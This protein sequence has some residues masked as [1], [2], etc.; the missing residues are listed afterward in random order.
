MGQ[1]HAEAGTLESGRRGRAGGNR[2]LTALLALTGALVVLVFAGAYLLGVMSNALFFLLMAMAPLTLLSRTWG[3]FRGRLEYGLVR[4]P[5]NRDLRLH[6]LQCVNRSVF[7]GIAGLTIALCMVPIQIEPDTYFDLR[8]FLLVSTVVMIALQLVPP[9]RVRISTNISYALGWIFLAVEWLRVFL[10][11]AAPEGVVLSAP[12]RG[13]WYV[14]QGG[15]SALLNHHFVLR[16]QR[17]AL[18]LMKL[19]DGR[20]A[21]GDPNQLESYAA[22]GQPLFAP[23]AGRVVKAVNDRPD[24]AIGKSDEQ[25]IVGNHLIIEVRPDRYVLMAHL[26]KGSVSVA[27]GERVH[28]G[29]LIA[30]C[31]NS[32]NTSEPHLHLQVQNR[33]SF[34]SSD[35][36]TFPI[37]FRDVTLMRQGRTWPGLAKDLRRNDRILVAP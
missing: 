10:P 14:V 36:V 9:R 15:R 17:C 5:L 1:E 37:L 11:Q 27:E 28:A 13:E 34:Y 22:F 4:H 16:S 20:E 35:L 31:G 23:A 19:V 25:Q 32:G 26:K 24:M 21:K 12:F 8:I 33:P 7:W 30:R 18:D 29:Q 6:L 2:L 3:A